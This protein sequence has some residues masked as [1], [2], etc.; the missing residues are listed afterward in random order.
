MA[1]VEME[2]EVILLQVDLPLQQ[3]QQVNILEVATQR[4][5]LMDIVMVSITTWTAT[6][7]VETVVDV[8]SAYYTV[9]LWKIANVLI[10]IMYQLAHKQQH[11]FQLFLDPLVSQLNFF[12]I[13]IKS[14]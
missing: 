1:V 2:A 7:M 6:M 4:G 8:M 13:I 3:V 9:A 10:P 12:L 14:F 11:Q 5:L